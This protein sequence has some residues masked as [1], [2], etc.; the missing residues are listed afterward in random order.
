[1]S[2]RIYPKYS[3]TFIH[4]HISSKN[5]TSPFCC[6]LILDEWQTV[7]TL[8]GRRIMRRL[9]RVHTVCPGLSVQIL[10]V[11]T[12]TI[13]IYICTTGLHTRDYSQD[14]QSLLIIQGIMEKENNRHENIYIPSHLGLLFKE[15]TLSEKKC[16]PVRVAVILKGFK[17]RLLKWQQ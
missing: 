14:V 12:V 4:Y 17:C 15:N 7:Y 9:I 16:F 11:I 2:Y 13:F 10:T 3:D 1:M 8:I 5:R 6:L